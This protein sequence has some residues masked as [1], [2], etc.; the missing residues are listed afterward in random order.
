MK[1]KEKV[2]DQVIK[3]VEKLVFNPV[4]ENL[5][6]VGYGARGLIYFIIGLLAIMIIFGFSKGLQ[7]QQG[8]I[9]FIGQN[10]FG[11][12]LLGIVLIGLV[13]YS[14]WGLIRA[15]VDP[16]HKGKSFKGILERTGFF[17]SSVAYAILIIPTYNFIFG[18]PNGA[19]NGAQIIQ[20]RE[21]INNIFLIPFGKWIVFIIG[22][23][24]LGTGFFQIY[25]GLRHNFDKQIKPYALNAKQI[26]IIKT[27]GRFGTLARAVVFSLIGA[28]LLFAAYRSNSL[29]VRG[30]DGALL[31]LMNQPYGSLLL[32]IIAIGLI[33]LGIY[34]LLSGLWFKLK[35]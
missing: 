23:A 26:K 14:L 7:D 13:G 9:A 5:T 31:V 10:I 21:I 35:K 8:A 19:E 27:I 32:G 12:I 33:A 1:S 22:L 30:I 29:K 16:L 15:F 6:R 11:L 25:L 2:T 20:F 18:M 17:I 3:E 28:L 34:S 24:F 4:V